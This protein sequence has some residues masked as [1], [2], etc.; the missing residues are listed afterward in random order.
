[1][2]IVVELFKKGGWRFS[3]GLF[4]LSFLIVIG[5]SID[6][7]YPLGKERNFDD[8]LCTP[9]IWSNSSQ[10][11]ETQQQIVRSGTIPGQKKNS[12]HKYDTVA[13]SRNYPFGTDTIGTDPF[14]IVFSCISKYFIPLLIVLFIAIGLGCVFGV[15]TGY[16]DET[17]QGFCAMILSNS[18]SALPQLLLLMLVC[19]FASKGE[20][21]QSTSFMVIACTFGIAEST[22]VGKS[23][24]N[25]IHVLREEEFIDA[26]KELGVS[27]WRIISRHILW[28]NCRELLVIHG[29]FAT[30]SFIMMELYLGY[31]NVGN[32]DAWGNLLGAN[33]TTGILGNESLFP[34][35]L[36]AL[37]GPVTKGFANR[38][39]LFL[40]A[41][42]VVL[43]IFSLFLIGDGLVKY[44]GQSQES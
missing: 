10:V 28:F 3:T 39:L 41:S 44:S 2:K 17:K 23:I 14:Y 24:M 16:Y 6:L 30:A 19:I 27:D 42:V 37:F 9:S 12:V 7:L 22:R 18:I 40:P 36:T 4:I 29:I 38:W 5:L 1:M 15:M 25:K 34:A 11:K 21:N 33:A 31:F 20:L 8:G 43:F 35:E 13:C 32:F 26:A